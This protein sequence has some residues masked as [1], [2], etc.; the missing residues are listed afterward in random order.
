MYQYVYMDNGLARKK[1]SMNDELKCTQVMQ[2]L[3]GFISRNTCLHIF[4]GLNAMQVKWVNLME[5][6]SKLNLC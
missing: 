6:K 4:W 1:N 5:T 2:R 3:T